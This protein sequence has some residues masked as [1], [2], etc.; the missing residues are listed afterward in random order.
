MGKYN[1]FRVG[2]DSAKANVLPMMVLCGLGSAI[3]WGYYHVPLIVVLLSPL[4]QWQNEYGWFAAFL[5]RCVFCGLLP[6]VFV[7]TTKEQKVRRPLCV[8]VIQMLFAGVCGI[9]SGWVFQL[10][11]HLFGTGIDWQTVLVKTVVYQFVWVVLFFVPAGAV[12]YF[13]MAKDFSFART[14][15]EWPGCFLHEVILPNLLV[16]WGVWV[17]LSAVIHLFPT[18][19]Q[20][21]LTGFANAILSLLLLS[22]GRRVARRPSGL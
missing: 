4:E 21:Q 18:A 20:I 9:V 13:W 19:L 15:A 14:R 12:I 8:I 5:T 1:P 7:L 10:H 11:A 2:L 3:A 22:L 16:N 6:G 17:P